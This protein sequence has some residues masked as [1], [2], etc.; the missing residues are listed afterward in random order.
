M[1]ALPAHDDRRTESPDDDGTLMSA[2]TPGE[3]T[4]VTGAGS[5]QML[6]MR[7]TPMTAASLVEATGAAIRS[8]RKCVVGGHNVHSVYLYHHDAKMRR[9]YELA[10]Q[11]FLDGMPLVWF[12]RM[13]GL[14]VRR[15]HRNAPFDW[16]PGLLRVAEESG[17]RV[18]FLGSPPGVAERGAERLRARF[19]G[20]RLAARHGYFD[21]TPGSAEAE[22]VMAEIREFRPHILCVCMGMPRQEHWI[23][24]HLGEL[25]ANV[26]FSLGALLDLFAGEIHAP[27]RWVGQIGFEWLYRLVAHPRRVWRRYMVEPW[28]LLPHMIRDLV[29]RSRRSL[30]AVSLPPSD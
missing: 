3:A 19:P 24:D 17:W 23:V 25:E 10:S 13:L 18:F 8:G 5:Y 6:G 29:S 16:M 1:A 27:P 22:A 12:A 4:A 14:P 2:P 7:F 9:F 21:A 26:T 11:A 30:Q 28:F 15:E 20:L